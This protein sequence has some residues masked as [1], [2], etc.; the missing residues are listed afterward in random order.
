MAYVLEGHGERIVSDAEARG[1]SVFKEALA[2]ENYEVRP[3]LLMT[4]E[5]VPPDCALLVIASPE[6]PL[7]PNERA[8]LD[9]YLRAGGRALCLL[10][11]GR[12]GGLADFLLPW[13]VRLNDDLVYDA[14]PA[15]RFL[16]A[17]EM[18][19][20]VLDYEDHPITRGFRL[21]TLYREA[22]TLEPAEGLHGGT[23]TGH[24]RTS[25]ESFA[26][27]GPIHA[28]RRIDPKTDRGG[29]LTLALAVETPAEPDTGEAAGARGQGRLV[30]IGDADIATNQYIGVQ[31]NRDL[32]LNTANWLAGEESLISIRARHPEDRRVNLTR[33]QDRLV[34]YGV[35]I[36]LPMMVLAAGVVVWWRRR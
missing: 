1:L 31:G 13:G 20:L 9:S 26:L 5:A 18:L 35:Q 16:G 15:S 12:D 8:A 28:G 27:Q 10:D 3:L 25:R 36:L 11:P 29:P 2:A 7:L 14:N 32:L 34:F 17:G 19:P 30:V 21:A 33:R 6:K 23:V 22:R 4:L 24:A